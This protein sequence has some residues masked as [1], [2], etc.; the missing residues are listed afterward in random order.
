M[1]Q[2]PSV[3]CRTWASAIPCDT[4][5]RWSRQRRPLSALKDFRSVRD[6]REAVGV[7]QE[8]PS[9]TAKDPFAESAVAVGAGYNHLGAD[10]LP[11]RLERCGV[12][13][14]REFSQ[15]F[16]LDPAAC[17]PCDH[18]VDATAGVA[19]FVGGR[20]LHHRHCLCVQQQRQRA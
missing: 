9:D 5:L 19:Q 17:Q 2:R 18:V 13:A 14:S 16:S 1:D 8:V 10:V 6:E 7:E 4:V 3:R 20:E 12:V 11:Q 15:A